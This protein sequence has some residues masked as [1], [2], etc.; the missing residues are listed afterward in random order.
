[1]KN[2]AF[3]DSLCAMPLS[4]KIALSE[5]CDDWNNRVGRNVNNVDVAQELM[6]SNELEN[7]DELQASLI[8]E[9][10]NYGIAFRFAQRVNAS[11]DL[12]ECELWN[13]GGGFMN[14]RVCLSD[15][16]AVLVTDDSLFILGLGLG[17]LTWEEFSDLD[18]DVI[19]SNA[20]TRYEF[21]NVHGTDNVGY[22]FNVT[23]HNLSKTGA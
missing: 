10:E 4:A 14:A 23:V 17:L 5:I 15:G 13:T 9:Y 12:P 7:I 2:K 16:R 6:A 3:V 1:M 21:S 18:D 20:V 19:V 8:A 11:D 22:A